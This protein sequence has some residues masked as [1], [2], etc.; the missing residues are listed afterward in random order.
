MIVQTTESWNSL[1]MAEFHDIIPPNMN[2]LHGIASFVC[3]E[4]PPEDEV[5]VGCHGSQEGERWLQPVR[6]YVGQQQNI[7][8]WPA[9]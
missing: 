5:F 1:D 2:L 9:V 6:H 4:I 7:R 8:V 3:T